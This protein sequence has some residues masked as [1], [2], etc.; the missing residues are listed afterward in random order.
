[1]RC[2]PARAKELLDRPGTAVMM[3][4]GRPMSTGWIVVDVDECAT[5][6]Q[7]AAWID[8]SLALIDP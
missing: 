2:R 5:V 8:E 4:N 3:M 7:V 6:D 1:M